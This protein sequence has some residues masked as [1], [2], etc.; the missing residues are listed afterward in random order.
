[1]NKY[2]GMLSEVFILSHCLIYFSY[3]IVDISRR[4]LNFIINANRA[5]SV[6]LGVKIQLNETFC[7]K[8]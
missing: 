6:V 4:P 8:C 7:L 2:T 1:M 5:Y 3:Y